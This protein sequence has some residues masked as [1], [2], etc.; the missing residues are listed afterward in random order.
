[1]G[2]AMSAMDFKLYGTPDTA[3]QILRMMSLSDGIGGV[4]QALPPA[5]RNAGTRLLDR[6]APSSGNGNGSV[7]VGVD[8]GSAQPLINE[9]K[10]ALTTLI[11]EAECKGITLRA[12]VDL[13]LSRASGEQYATLL[14]IQGALIVLPGIGDQPLEVVLAL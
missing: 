4:I 14:K 7:P 11:P 3:Q 6:V 12:A 1:M 2:E 5:V 8:L 10:A 9:G 13:A